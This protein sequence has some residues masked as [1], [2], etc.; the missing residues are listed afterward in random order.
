MAMT[1]SIV[2][3]GDK[4]K[5]KKKTKTPQYNDGLL[6]DIILFKKNLNAAKKP[7]E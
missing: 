5:T 6:P 2:Y 1:R 3:K 7:P 4:N